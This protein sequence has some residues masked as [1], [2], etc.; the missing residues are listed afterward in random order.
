MHSYYNIWGGT[1]QNWNYLME[2]GPLQYRL[3]PLGECSR[4]PSVSVHQ[5]A[6]LWE[7][8]LTFSELF[9]KTLSMC[10]PLSWWVTYERTRPPHWVFSSFWS[11]MAWLPLRAPPTLFTPSHH[12]RLF[13]FPWM[14]SPQ[15]ETFCQ[16]GR[17]ETKNVWSTKGHQNQRVQETVEQWQK[18]LNRCIASHGEYFEGDRSLNIRICAQFFINKFQGL[19][20]YP[21]CINNHI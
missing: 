12:K 8:A 21:P 14:K 6:L 17:S 9:L 7:A 20:G 18:H 11:K 16:H 19:G 4:N 13:L 3:P 15:R 2:G 10:L 1:P 5:L